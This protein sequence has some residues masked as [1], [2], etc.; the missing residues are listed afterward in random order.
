ML[1]HKEVLERREASENAEKEQR[2]YSIRDQVF[3]EK[4]GGQW[5]DESTQARLKRPRLTVDLIS[6]ALD[7]AIGDQ[8]ET[9][10]TVQVVPKKGGTEDV[11]KIYT[12]L[13]RNIEEESNAQD[14]YDAAYDEQL[15]ARS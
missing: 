3:I 7:Q 5:D 12:G 8:R 11:A 10:T 4:E 15:K 14:I 1:S 9:E 2:Q 13:L 6:G